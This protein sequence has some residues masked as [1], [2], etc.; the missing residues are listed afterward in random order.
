MATTNQ[1]PRNAADLDIGYDLVITKTTR[2]AAGAGTWVIGTI[3]GHRFDAL[4]FPEH[5]E[6]PGYEL[7]DSRISKLWIKRLSDEKEERTS[8][9]FDFEHGMIET[10]EIERSI[11]LALEVLGQRKIA[12]KKKDSI[13]INPDRKEV[14]EYYRNSI[15][16]LFEGA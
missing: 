13:V 14:L 11:D 12:K 16:H 1:E 7:D 10:E 2:R 4:V 5:A 15:I 8:E 3:S 9:L 6:C